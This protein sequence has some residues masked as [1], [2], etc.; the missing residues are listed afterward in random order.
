[1]Q[2]TLGIILFHYFST[3]CWKTVGRCSATLGA[4]PPMLYPHQR[5]GP[6]L[7]LFQCASVLLFW[8]PQNCKASRVLSRGSDHVSWLASCRRLVGP[9][10]KIPLKG[11]FFLSI[12][13]PLSP[14]GCQLGTCW[15]S[16]CPN[17]QIKRSFSVSYRV[18]FGLSRIGEKIGEY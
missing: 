18:G 6:L 4:S 11:L 17:V 10:L 9:F 7:G 14:V 8:G 15:G 3:S 13:T 5:G 1:M 2:L 16:L 12:S